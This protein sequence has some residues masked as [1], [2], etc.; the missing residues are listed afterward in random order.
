MATSSCCLSE[1][2]TVHIFQDGF[3]SGADS[4][5]RSSTA[6]VDL[7]FSEHARKA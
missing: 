7:A 1:G 2:L 5:I 3:G 4:Y 6:D